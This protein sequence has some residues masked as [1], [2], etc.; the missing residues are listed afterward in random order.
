M[1]ELT[2]SIIRPEL[3][4]KRIAAA[5]LPDVWRMFDD[6]RT[7]ARARG[8]AWPGYMWMPLEEVAPDIMRA[9]SAL[10]ASQGARPEVITSILPYAAANAYALATWR[11]GKGV[12]RF[13]DDLREALLETPVSGP[14][15]TEVLKRLPEWCVYV[16]TPGYR[17]EGLDVHG[18]F[19]CITRFRGEDVL[20]LSMDMTDP[21]T[22]R[23]IAMI[24]IG[25]SHATIE[26]ALMD[27]AKRSVI[28]TGGMVRHGVPMSDRSAKAIADIGSD[29]EKLRESVER[30]VADIGPLLSL[31][32]YLCAED[33]ELDP[34]PPP[35]PKESRTKRG[36]RFFAARVPRLVGVGLRLGARLRDARERP[37]GGDRESVTGTVLPHL[38]RA[39]WHTYLYGPRSGERERRLR[40]LHP[41]LV[42]ERARSDDAPAV[43]HPVDAPP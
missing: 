3:W 18:F 16:E 39:H 33:R 41:T 25:L 30:V 10:M 31:A 24:P 6:A 43:L 32:L 4:A 36:G 37:G 29:P 17:C 40:W 22:S 2:P 27:N 13:D 14:I 9:L 11:L 20:H 19:A 5:A 34:V 21:E 8:K 23:V 28:L 26:D 35:P 1:A 7:A 12:Y 38:R 15:P 42:N